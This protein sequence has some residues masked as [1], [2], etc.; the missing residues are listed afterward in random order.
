MSWWKDFKSMFYK[1]NRDIFAKEYRI[2]ERK[3]PDS[4]TSFIIQSRYINGAGGA[5]EIWWDDDAFIMMKQFMS[6]EE[7]HSCLSQYLH[8]KLPIDE[9]VWEQKDEI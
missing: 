4:G 6:L 9:V 1:Q 3:W 2:V 5:E 7:A 8:P